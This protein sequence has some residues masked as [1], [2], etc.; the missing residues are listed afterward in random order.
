MGLPE[1]AYRAA[2]AFGADPQNASAT[3]A[4]FAAMDRMEGEA[5]Q[6]NALSGKPVSI[7]S[8][9]LVHP[10]IARHQ[11]VLHEYHERLTRISDDTGRYLL[12]EGSNHFSL[13]A[14]EFYA[15]Q[16]ADEIMAVVNLT[17]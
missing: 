10:R 5:D 16:V 9:E 13:L 3:A 15:D 12:L 6:L 2:R 1:Y 4:E 14:N 11:Y 7:I 17:R 8:A